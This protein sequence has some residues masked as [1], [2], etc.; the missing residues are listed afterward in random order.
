MYRPLTLA[1]FSYLLLR[2]S[3][4]FWVFRE[5]VKRQIVL[6][7]TSVSED[8]MDFKLIKNKRTNHHRIVS[9]RSW[10]ENDALTWIES[11]IIKG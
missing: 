11:N 10:I 1:L 2:F 9:G 4:S 8:K 3:A 6:A 7:S 5:S